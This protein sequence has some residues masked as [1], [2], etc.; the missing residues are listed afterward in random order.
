MDPDLGCERTTEV[1][2]M[3]RI[4][5]IGAG[6]VGRALGMY[7][8]GN[9]RTV[10]GYYSRSINSAQ[11][12][13]ACIGATYY[14]DLK[15]VA[16][17]SDVLFL[18][19]PDRSIGQVWDQ[20]VCLQQKGEVLLNGKVLVH[21][22]GSLSSD[23]FS[24]L[25]ETGAFGFSLHPIL[26]VS[27]PEIAVEQFPTCIFT[28]EGEA[29]SRKEAFFSE[30]QAM[31]LTVAQISKEKKVRYHG[32]CVMAS[33]LVNG[34]LAASQQMLMGCGLDESLCEKA[35]TPL[36]LGNANAA[37]TRGPIQSLTG[38]IQRGDMVTVQKHIGELS[39]EKDDAELL[40]IYTALSNYLEHHKGVNGNER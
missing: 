8:S 13:A 38:P 9:G 23:I 31:G 28:L 14:E 10:S 15:D 37:A 21:C 39:K 35:L 29:S 30:L 40:A 36:F 25:S 27:D 32:A 2:G 6:K 12:A 3:Q 26:A 1:M 22:S 11:N 20:L 4:G 24:N 33:N 19:V 18:T 7:F 17:A 34:L 5:F 16:N